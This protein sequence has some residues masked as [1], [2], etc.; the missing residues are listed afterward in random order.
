MVCFFFLPLQHANHQLAGAHYLFY[1]FGIFN[2]L[3]WFLLQM[4]NKYYSQLW[5][6]I[7]S[8][9]HSLVNWDKQ[10]QQVAVIANLVSHMPKHKQRQKTI[11]VQPLIWAHLWSFVGS[12]Y[13]YQLI[14]LS[15]SVIHSLSSQNHLV[16]P[17]RYPFYRLIM[18]KTL[19]RFQK[20][21]VQHGNVGS[22]FGLW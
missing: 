8:I 10:Q 15:F 2:T 16:N 13:S 5:R 17:S 14:W 18:V 11:H 19:I 4:N 22:R 3:G 20:T 7:I 6:S 1:F 21:T 12:S 9:F